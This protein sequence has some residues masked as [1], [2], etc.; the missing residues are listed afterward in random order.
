[1]EDLEQE[2]DKKKKKESPYLPDKDKQPISVLKAVTRSRKVVLLGAPGAG[3]ST[4][5]KKLCG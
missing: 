3:K 4:F 5:V 1:L 2:P